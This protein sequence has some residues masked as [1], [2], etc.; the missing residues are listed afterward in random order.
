VIPARTRQQVRARAGA[1][2][3]Y[4]RLPDWVEWSGP[5]HVEH[6][7][8]RQHGGGEDVANLAWA[9]SRCNYRKGPNLSAVDPDGAGIVPLFHPRR[10]RWAEHFALEGARVRGLTPAGRAT[11]WLL[12][13]NAERRLELRAQLI[14]EGL[15]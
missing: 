12:Q 8:A 5:F 3:E 7:V 2:C 14:R 13:M 9:C 6:V 4:C 1:R 15:W 11:V 10:D